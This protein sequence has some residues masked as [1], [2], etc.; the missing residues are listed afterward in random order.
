MVS[1]ST[2]DGSLP[3]APWGRTPVRL[4]SAP[5]RWRPVPLPLQR[6]FD[7]LGAPLSQVPFCVLDIETTGGG[8]AP[9]RRPPPRGAPR[10]GGDGVCGGRVTAQVPHPDRSRPPHPPFH[11]D[12]H[13]DHPC[14]A[15]RGPQGGRGP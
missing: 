6:S 1:S 10:G 2:G 15:G 4:A 14:H 5:L 12:P 8:P 9:P 11:H 13:R 3:V 7:D